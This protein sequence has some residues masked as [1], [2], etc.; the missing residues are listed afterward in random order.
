ML[1]HFGIDTLSRKVTLRRIHVLLRRL[2]AGTWPDPQSEMSWSLESHLL[3]GVL[4]TLGALVYVTLKANGSK[5]AK[6]PKPVQRPKPVRPRPP[7]NV[8]RNEKTGRSAWA[9]LADAL[10]GQKGTEVIIVNG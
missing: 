5:S 4:D 9:E 3:A 2:P 1:A 8:P 7:V 6:P 10:K